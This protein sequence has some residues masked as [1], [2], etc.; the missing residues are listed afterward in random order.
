MMDYK[1]IG[2]E[3]FNDLYGGNIVDSMLCAGG[4]TAVKKA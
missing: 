1:H 2:N 4:L 3:R